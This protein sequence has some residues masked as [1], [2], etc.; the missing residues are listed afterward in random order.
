MKKADIQVYWRLLSYLKPY[1]WAGALALVGYLI[2]AGTEVSVAKLVGFIINAINHQ[3]QTAKN[4]FPA[5]LFKLFQKI[6]RNIKAMLFQIS[7]GILL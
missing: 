1:W 3:D 7:A 2:N 5:L 6:M 4:L